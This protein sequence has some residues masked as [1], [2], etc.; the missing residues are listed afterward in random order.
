MEH[1]AYFKGIVRISVFYSITYVISQK[2]AILQFSFCTKPFQHWNSKPRNLEKKMQ[3]SNP[4]KILTTY[5][6]F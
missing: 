1:P 5:T 6:L 4:S 2:H 3:F